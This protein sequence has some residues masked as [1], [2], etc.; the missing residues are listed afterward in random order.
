MSFRET[1]KN[2]YITDDSS[3]ERLCISANSP[4]RPNFPKIGKE[5]EVYPLPLWQMKPNFN[6]IENSPV[7]SWHNLLTG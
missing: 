1:L 6:N 3:P 7:P 2:K 4:R 5:T